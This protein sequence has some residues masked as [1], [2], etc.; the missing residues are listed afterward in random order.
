MTAFILSLASFLSGCD[1]PGTSDTRNCVVTPRCHCASA[2]AS[3]FVRFI[4]IQF[5]MRHLT[6]HTLWLS[7]SRPRPHLHPT[8]SYPAPA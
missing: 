2:D 5:D 3:Q 7:T 4:L 8:A 6:K 1:Y